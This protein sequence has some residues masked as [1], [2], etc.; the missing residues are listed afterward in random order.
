MKALVVGA[1]SYA[2]RHALQAFEGARGVDADGDIEAAAEGV[3][4]IL[5]CAPTW[6]PDRKPQAARAPHPL[7]ARVLGAARGAGVKRLVHLSTAAVYG[8]DHVG[9][10]PETAAPR[11]A[12][13]YEKL[14]LREEEWLRLNRGGLEIV[15]VRA[16]AGFGSHDPILERLLRQLRAGNLRL[17]GGGRA[18]RTFLA[19]PDLGRVL[20][21]A[22]VRGRAGATYL[23]GGFDGTWRDLLT[24]AAAVM[25][26]PA[27]IRSIPYDLAYLDAALRWLRA[28][29]GEECWPNPYGLDLLAKSHV[30]DDAGSRRDLSW[31]PQ[32]GS[33]DE[34]VMELVNWFQQRRQAIEPPAAEESLS[35]SRQDT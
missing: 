11:P 34:G 4:V 35:I 25:G 13:A 15:V 14:K 17:A 24:M 31:S 28:H 20:H 21:A 22:A 23:A 18:E 27:R 30:Y 32:V 33:F 3:D 19:G 9:R 5:L 26:I 12:H 10:I 2:G 6:E 16:A 1:S 7:P 8:P 29:G